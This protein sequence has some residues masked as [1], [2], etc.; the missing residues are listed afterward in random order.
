MTVS[1]NRISKKTQEALIQMN[2]LTLSHQAAEL[3]LALTTV[4][5]YRST[6]IKAGMLK[7]RVKRFADFTPD[8]IDRVR[9][10]ASYGYSHSGIAQLTE[11][12]VPQVGRICKEHNI[13]TGEGYWTLAD[14]EQVMGIP[15]STVERWR[16]EEWIT[17]QLTKEVGGRR[18]SRRSVRQLVTRRDMVDFLTIR[19]AWP[20]YQPS[21]INDPELR[22][23]A[24]MMRCSARGRWVPL[25]DVADMAGIYF[26]RVARRMKNGWLADWEWTTIGRARYLWM[27]DGS[28]LPPYIERW[29][30]RKQK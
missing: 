14:L 10:L 20:S 19:A 11:F 29:K 12:S 1:L 21:N 30:G 23:A 5:A 13:K 17:P 18:R 3:R 25:S 16:D 7:S 4:R 22:Q 2:G 15:E 8:Q 26:T 24:E 28:M 27:P 9:R 6:L